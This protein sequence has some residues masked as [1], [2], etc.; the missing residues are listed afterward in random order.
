MFMSFVNQYLKFFVLLTPFFALSA[1]LTLTSEKEKEEKRSI[2]RRITIAVTITVLVLVFV[3]Q[4]LFDLFGITLDAFRIGAG[5]VLFVSAIRMVLG[6]RESASAP[7][8]DDVAVVPISIPI[9]VGPG[10]IGA[11]LVMGAQTVGFA[12]KVLSV[13]ALLAAVIST[14]LLLATGEFIERALGRQG[15]T[16]LS[17]LTGLFVSAIAAQIIIT[18]LKNLLGH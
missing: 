8:S 16:V 1:F 9:I 13:G 3:G 5:S 4:L 10:T 11:I 6:S 12:P 15:I 18:G 2:V 17:K 7:G 14:G